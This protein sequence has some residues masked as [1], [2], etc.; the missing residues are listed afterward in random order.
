MDLNTA[1][2]LLG[3]PITFDA[4]VNKLVSDLGFTSQ[5]DDGSTSTYIRDNYIVTCTNGNNK[6]W[7][8]EQVENEKTSKIFDG[9]IGVTIIEYIAFNELD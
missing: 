8:L 2:G 7:I 5:S 3:E 1:I 6:S 9:V 4:I